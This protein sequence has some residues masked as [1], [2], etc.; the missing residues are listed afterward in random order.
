MA[1]IATFL[2]LIASFA[3][4]LWSAWRDRSRRID[5]YLYSGNTELLGVSSC[6]GSVVSMAV[7]FTA[8]LSAGYLWGWQILFSIVPGCLVGLGLLLCLSRHPLIADHQVA[9]E[10]QQLPDGASYISLFAS[11]KP[12]LFA[13]YVFFLVAYAAMLLT[14]L[15][16]LRTFM[17]SLT[18]LPAPELTLTIGVIAFVCFA[19]VFIG[20]FRGVLV[21]DYFQLLVVIAFVGVWLAT[22]VHSG[23]WSVPGPTTSRLH[24]TF[25]RL[26]LLHVGCFCGALAWMFASIDQW[27]RT[28]GTLPLITA[29]R[30]AITAA[31]TLSLMIAVPVLAGSSA[32]LRHDVPPAVSNGIS[33]FLVRGMVRGSPAGI[34]FLFVMALVCA[35]LTTLNTYV[36][37]IQQLYYEFS[38]RLTAHR[39]WTYVVTEM[40]A[41][42][43]NVRMVSLVLLIVAFVGSLL[44]PERY[45]YMFGVLSLSTFVFAVPLLINELLAVAARNPAAAETPWARQAHVALWIA[46]ILCGALLIAARLLLGSITE[47]LYVIP[48]A[49]A[50]AS[51][52]GSVIVLL[53]RTQDTARNVNLS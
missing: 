47:H 31:A 50:A 33:L 6:I 27:Y 24:W 36:I 43:R 44:M 34:R 35:A 5:S 45:V 42:W 13:F 23:P 30:V 26:L 48:A 53:F 25:W 38:I 2:V 19:Y 39:F 10:G 52:I 20:G 12:R 40:V 8:L 16:V 46:I 15:T 11:R 29:R 37:T 41:K 22:L 17:E 32:L 21:T 7:S 18:A 3:I 51:L 14:E 1:V 49:A 28:F 4:S 9:V